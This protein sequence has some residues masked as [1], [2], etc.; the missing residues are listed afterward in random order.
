MPGPFKLTLHVRPGGDLPGKR[1]V[2]G[3]LHIELLVRAEWDNVERV[4]RLIHEAALAAY[5]S[6]DVADA[7][8]MMAAELL[9]NAIRHGRGHSPRLLVD[10]Q[11][12]K[13][14]VAITSSIVEAAPEHLDEL[15]RRIELLNAFSDPA[16]AFRAT[17]RERPRGTVNGLGLARVLFEG[18]CRLDC[19]TSRPA[20][21]TVRATTRFAPRGDS[22]QGAA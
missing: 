4:R 19:D 12:D 16:E 8:G 1:R 5:G 7:L 9:D 2:N 13:L 20:E 15:R 10:D 3:A 6:P 14:S 17:I 22:R 18:D 21:V 11:G